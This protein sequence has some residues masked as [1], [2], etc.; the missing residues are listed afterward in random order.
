MADQKTKLK[1]I[2][3]QDDGAVVAINLDFYHTWAAQRRHQE[4]SIFTCSDRHDR[5][6]SLFA[7]SFNKSANLQ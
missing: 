2:S 6:D 1:K 7:A 4:H 3:I 5:H